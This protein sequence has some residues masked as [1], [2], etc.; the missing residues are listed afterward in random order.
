[1]FTLLTD[2]GFKGFTDISLEF[3][4]TNELSMNFRYA[5]QQV[6]RAVFLISEAGEL[7]EE[8]EDKEEFIRKCVND[9]KGEL[10]KTTFIDKSTIAELIGGRV[11]R[12]SELKSIRIL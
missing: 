9:I 12:G 2:N 8:K 11:L 4:G 5:G 10:Q 6:E 7:I 3:S 1:M